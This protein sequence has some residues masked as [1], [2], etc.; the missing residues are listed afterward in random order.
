MS[1]HIFGHPAKVCSSPM[2]WPF[3]TFGPR[4]LT[5]LVSHPF[6]TRPGPHPSSPFLG[7]TL[8]FWPFPIFYTPFIPFCLFS[9][10]APL[11]LFQFPFCTNLSLQGAQCTEFSTKDMG[12][13]LPAFFD[14]KTTL[15]RKEIIC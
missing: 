7:P 15:Q 10:Y 14:K 3:H 4:G 5:V 8:F 9:Y 1:S 11:S 13:L 12:S 6:C 2:F